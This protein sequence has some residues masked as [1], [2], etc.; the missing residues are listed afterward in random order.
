MKK[1]FLLLFMVSLFLCQCQKENEGLNKTTISSL[2][3]KS[4]SIKP[5]L[6]IT[7]KFSSFSYQ[8]DP[9]FGNGTCLI[10]NTQGWYSISTSDNSTPDW[11][12][13]FIKL[14]NVN[15]VQS[16]TNSNCETLSSDFSSPEFEFLKGAGSTGYSGNVP[17]YQ[18]GQTA[19]NGS[20]FRISPSTISDQYDIVLVSGDGLPIEYNS[21]PVPN[22]RDA[23]ITLGRDVSTGYWKIQSSV[24]VSS[25]L[26][27]KFDGPYTNGEISVILPAN[28]QSLEINRDDENLFPVSVLPSSDQNYDYTFVRI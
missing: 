12:Y 20:S 28:T 10:Y 9:T 23:L 2:T 6:T 5:I 18:T 4:G 1:L 3:K 7:L 27:L 24:S 21:I 11:Y 16:G 25:D 15:A 8:I 14:K 13:F 22:P 17:C 26:T 19:I